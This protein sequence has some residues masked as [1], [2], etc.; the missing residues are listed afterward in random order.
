[1]CCQ[2]DSLDSGWSLNVLFDPYSK[3]VIYEDSDDVARPERD[4]GQMTLH[5]YGFW[6]AAIHVQQVHHTA[7]PK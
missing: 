3:V 4:S 6:P 2:V 5:R 7:V 1:M